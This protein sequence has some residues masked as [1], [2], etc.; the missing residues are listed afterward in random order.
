MKPFD[1][2]G[3]GNTFRRLKSFEMLPQGGIADAWASSGPSTRKSFEI[4]P[5]TTKGLT[6]ASTGT[7]PH[8][9][10]P[11]PGAAT[12]GLPRGMRGCDGMCG[13]CTRLPKTSKRPDSLRQRLSEYL[14]VI[15]EPRTEVS[16]LDGTRDNGP[17]LPAPATPNEKPLRLGGESECARINREVAE[18]IAELSREITRGATYERLCR[19]CEIHAITDCFAIEQLIRDLGAQQMLLQQAQGMYSSADPE[20]WELNDQINSININQIPEL[21]R[22]DIQCGLDIQ[23]RAI[24][25]RGYARECE[26]RCDGYFRSIEHESDLILYVIKALR[27]YTSRVRELNRLF[28]LL[29]CQIEEYGQTRILRGL[30]AL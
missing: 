3:P 11:L 15:H 14:G 22:L 13:S 24:S 9:I 12:C 6:S 29:N 16:P 26:L 17:S 10:M 18:D 28:P 27:N 2:H 21:L 20:W 30:R 25:G 5:V 19:E 7:K 4:M 23:N 8:E 1:V